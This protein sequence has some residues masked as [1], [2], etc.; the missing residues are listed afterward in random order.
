MCEERGG[1]DMPNITI[2]IDE[3][4]LKAGRKYAEKH[5]TSINALIRK[6]L[7]ETIQSQTKD[8]LQE[9][10]DLMDRAKGNSR[11]KTWKR[12]ELYDV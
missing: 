11:G 8:W 3:A 5:Q 9:C 12:E 1:A 10:F 4:L 2:S 7:E 6:L